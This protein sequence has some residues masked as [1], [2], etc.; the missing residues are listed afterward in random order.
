MANFKIFTSSQE[1]QERLAT[2]KAC[3]NYDAEASK[4]PLCNCYMPLKVRVS[5][6]KCP[7]GR[8]GQAKTTEEFDIE[9]PSW[10]HSKGITGDGVIQE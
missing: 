4:C 1:Q 9:D 6:L 10:V 3:P 2:C 7:D 8:W 5:W